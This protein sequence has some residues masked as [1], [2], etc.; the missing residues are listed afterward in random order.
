MVMNYLAKKNALKFIKLTSLLGVISLLVLVI[1]IVLPADFEPSTSTFSYAD[2]T[3][4]AFDQHYVYVTIDDVGVLAVSQ[5]D[6]DIVWQYPDASLSDSLRVANPNNIRLEGN[7]LYFLS[8]DS[9]FALDATEGEALWRSRLNIKPLSQVNMLSTSDSLLVTNSNAGSV[10][11]IDTM[12]RE[13]AW[14][15]NIPIT[16][17]N[18]IMPLSLS[19][20]RVIV[21]I[22][23]IREEEG[24]HGLSKGRLYVISTLSG[25]PLWTQDLRDWI[26]LSFIPMPAIQDEDENIYLVVG[27]NILALDGASGA[28]KWSTRWRHS[29]YKD[30]V[31]MEDKVAAIGHSAMFA[32][33][34][35]AGA[36]LCREAFHPMRRSRDFLSQ[37]NQKLYFVYHT[38]ERQKILWWHTWKTFNRSYIYVAEA[39]TCKFDLYADIPGFLLT[40]DPATGAVINIPSLHHDLTA[41]RRVRITP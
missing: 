20:K 21:L 39:G 30:L 23:D 40:Y 26:T 36:I 1:K 10:Y 37:G 32:V 28:T 19:P 16:K 14:T 17:G 2:V 5:E 11:L 3:S 27:N 9:V 33:T 29:V 35:D 31:L 41:L 15:F 24:V 8:S 18:R 6:G 22:G 7:T 13:V 38:H 12:Q 4:M 34:R 25:N